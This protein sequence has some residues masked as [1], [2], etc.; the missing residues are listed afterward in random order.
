MIFCHPKSYKEWVLDH[1]ENHPILPMPTIAIRGQPTTR[2]PLSPNTDLRNKEGAL[3]EVIDAW[4]EFM[5]HVRWIH[6]MPEGAYALLQLSYGL[7]GV[8]QTMKN[9][10][11]DL[12]KYIAGNLTDGLVYGKNPRL[13]DTTVVFADAEFGHDHKTGQAIY[14]G[15]ILCKGGLIDYKSASQKCVTLSST[16][17]ETVA[18]SK[19]GQRNQKCRAYQ[20]D[21]GRPPIGPSPFFEDNKGTV[22]YTRGAAPTRN[23]RHIR[24]RN[25]YIR[26]LQRDGDID[27]RHCPGTEQVA[28]IFTKALPFATVVKHKEA[29]GMCTLE[30]FRRACAAS[31]GGSTSSSAYA[32]YVNDR[33]LGAFFNFADAG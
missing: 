8:T 13:S 32:S 23:M 25:A 31:I 2:V 5:G 27:M 29:M 33:F 3:T 15:V 4:Q 17:A 6:T 9:A 26:E 20:V 10:A 28:D 7:T 19:I 1:W 11:H 16:E 21:Q 18:A 24:Q 22:D 30:D 12:L 14:G